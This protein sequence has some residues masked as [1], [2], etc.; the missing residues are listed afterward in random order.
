[1]CIYIYIYIYVYIYIYIYSRIKFKFCVGCLNPSNVCVCVSV[2]VQGIVCT[3]GI[4]KRF[5]VL[6]IESSI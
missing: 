6:A 2:C 5:L 4:C 3:L 1:M